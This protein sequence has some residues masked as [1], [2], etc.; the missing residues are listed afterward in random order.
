[1]NLRK[2]VFEL[3]SGNWCDRLYRTLKFRII[4]FEAF[5]SLLP[6][7]GRILDLGCGYGYLA[8]YLSLEGRRYVVGNDTSADRVAVARETIGDRKNI[9]FVQTDFR[10]LSVEPF[11]GVVI[12]DVLHHIPYEDQP[13]VLEDLHKK[14]KTEGILVIRE[15]DKRSSLRYWLFNYLL[16]WFLYWGEE[17]LRFRSKK[18]WAR[19]LSDSGYDVQRLIPNSIWSPY[20]T[21]VFVC[22]KRER[23]SSP[24]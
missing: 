2:Q 19:L 6:K 10:M 16:E 18:E 17:K 7:E 20:I 8:N 21:A 11:D 12:A 3:Y 23:V 24:L 5:S 9:E 1:M 4:P 14:L 22:V 13:A 15:T